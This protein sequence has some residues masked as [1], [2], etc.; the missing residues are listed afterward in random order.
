M[1]SV[2]TLTNFLF[3]H[4]FKCCGTVTFS[5]GS[6]SEIHFPSCSSGSGSDFTN[7]SIKTVKV[8]FELTT[9]EFA[10][11]LFFFLVGT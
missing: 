3:F 11:L 8:D 6:G 2:C 1:H 10:L 5:C 4:D 7:I 9:A